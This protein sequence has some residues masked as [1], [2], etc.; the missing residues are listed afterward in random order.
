MVF[1]FVN[2][3]LV[4]I[5]KIF[6]KL[7]WMFFESSVE[8][9]KKQEEKAKK[10]DIFIFS[11]SGGIDVFNSYVC[12][13]RIRFCILEAENTY[14]AVLK[15]SFCMYSQNS[16]SKDTSLLNSVPLI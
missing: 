14:T 1:D 12:T 6:C 16:I 7:T 10:G 13:R 11:V 15:M 3:F 5:V 9:N 2:R 4:T 8:T